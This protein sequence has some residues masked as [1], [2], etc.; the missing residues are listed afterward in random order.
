M[1]P[2]ENKTSYLH[3]WDSD[4]RRYFGAF[5]TNISNL[6]RGIAG[7]YKNPFTA[8]KD[9]ILYGHRYLDAE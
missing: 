9:P 3:R 2:V 5:E 8:M 7:L 1:S 4:A 6:K